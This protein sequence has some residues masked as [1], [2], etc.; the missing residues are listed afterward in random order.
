[1]PKSGQPTFLET[2]AVGD[3]TRLNYH[4]ILASFSVFA[5]MLGLDITAPRCVPAVGDLLDQVAAEWCDQEFF[6][7]HPGS[8]GTTLWAA[9]ADRWPEV[10]RWGRISL[11]RFHRA[12]LAWK[13]LAPGRTR[14][15][16]PLLHLALVVTD[17][18]RRRLSEVGVLLLLMFT[19]YL[20]PSEALS[21]KAA[22]VIP[23]SSACKFFSVMLHPE[24]G[25]VASK[26]GQF[27]DGVVLD[28]P[29]FPWLGPLLASMSRRRQ[30]ASAALFNIGYRELLKKFQ[31]SMHNCQIPDPSLYR[32]RHGGASN[33]RAKGLRTISSVK[34]RGRWVTDAAMKRYEKGVRLQ[35]IELGIPAAMLARARVEL[36]RLQENLETT[37][38]GR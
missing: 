31:T 15:P 8:R 24:E 9:L 28:S 26:T 18:I 29:E 19:A 4:M 2:H 22:D 16:L 35:R 25:L 17:L 5:G 32:I 10:G 36:G 6:E 21:L 1:M 3:A 27:Y 20:R 11:P 38:L 7:G 23:P 12:R 34:R 30:S 33:D 37:V 14:D 13:K